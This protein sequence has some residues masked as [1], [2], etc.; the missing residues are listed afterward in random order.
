MADTNR[1]D[2]AWVSEFEDAWMAVFVARRSGDEVNIASAEEQW[3]SLFSILNRDQAAFVA[4]T[5]QS[6]LAE[7]QGCSVSEV[8][9]QAIERNGLVGMDEEQFERIFVYGMGDA[10]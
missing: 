1:P 2:A 8:I 6:F 4:K 10:T 3:H 7:L 9:Q 5:M